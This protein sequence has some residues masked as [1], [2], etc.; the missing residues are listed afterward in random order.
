MLAGEVVLSD[1]DTNSL[2]LVVERGYSLEFYPT[3]H[4]TLKTPLKQGTKVVFSGWW[5]VKGQYTLQSIRLM[6]YNQCG[7]CGVVVSGLSQ[8]C[9]ETHKSK[10]AKVDGLW[11][12][13][14]KRAESH[15][16]RLWFEVVGGVEC[17]AYTAKLNNP[18]Y[19][20]L[21]NCKIGGYVEL[22]GW[23]CEPPQLKYCRSC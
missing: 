1:Q 3:Q 18:F 14:H 17:F 8:L 6:N 10:L 20:E 5:S 22:R 19:E 11:K 7:V 13:V 16:T 9:H 2:I 23:M 15:Y 21:T 12:V 4:P